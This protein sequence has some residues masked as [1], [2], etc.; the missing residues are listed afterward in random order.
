MNK[1]GRPYFQYRQADFEGAGKDS[2]NWP[3][4]GCSRPSVCT[5]RPSRAVAQSRLLRGPPDQARVETYAEQS[6]RWQR[7]L[8]VVVV[9]CSCGRVAFYRAVVLVAG[10]WPTKPWRRASRPF[11]TGDSKIT[12]SPDFREPPRNSRALP[13]GG[14]DIRPYVWTVAAL[15]PLHTSPAFTAAPSATASFNTTVR[16]I[17]STTT[18]PAPDH[19]RVAHQEPDHLSRQ[20]A[21]AALFQNRCGPC[22]C[23]MIAGPRL[24]RRRPH[25]PPEPRLT[26]YAR[27]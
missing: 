19:R 25:R 13:W 6:A 12:S 16:C 5:R 22:G 14:W 2:A 10:D 8:P 4:R 3:I 11:Q 9:V 18:T 26:E 7:H 23:A 15:T 17:A 24:Q 1:H 27:A 20:A 21:G